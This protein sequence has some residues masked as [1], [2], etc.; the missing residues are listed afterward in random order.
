MTWASLVNGVVDLAVRARRSGAAIVVRDRAVRPRVSEFIPSTSPLERR[1]RPRSPRRGRRNVLRPARAL[2][3]GPGRG[4]AGSLLPVRSGFCSEPGERELL[5]DDLLR[6]HEP[7]V[8]VAGAAQVVER[9]QGVE[10][11]EVRG[12]AAV[13][14]RASNHIEDG[15]GRIRMPWPRPDR[16]PVV[17][18]LDVV[19]HPVAVDDR[20]PAP[21]V[22]AEH[23]AVHVRGDAGRSG[24]PAAEPRRSGQCAA[25][26][27]GCRRSR[28][29]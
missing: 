11:G 20:P 29:R 23:P 19:P 28:R 18:A 2:P 25:R 26:G 6:Q 21:S 13:C 15:P 14:R 10:A 24:G 4:P 9:A 27:R 12:A 22:I 7:G 1:R 16:V 3:A 5:L 8:V 17:D